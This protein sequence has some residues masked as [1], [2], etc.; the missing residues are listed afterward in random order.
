MSRSRLLLLVVALACVG[1]LLWLLLPPQPEANRQASRVPPPTAQSPVLIAPPAPPPEPAPHP[2]AILPPPEVLALPMADGNPLRARWY[3]AT[4]PDAPIVVL[5]A[6]AGSDLRPWLLSIQALLAQR[7]AH[8]LWLDD[9]QPRHADASARRLRAVARWSVALAWLDVRAPTARLAL[10]GAHEA[11]DAIWRVASRPRPMSLA[12][13]APDQQPDEP[14]SADIVDRFTLLGLPLAGEPTPT[15]VG[16][17]HNARVW[18]I[19]AEHALE[20][21]KAQADLAG[22][23]FVALGPR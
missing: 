9:V 5:D 22:W 8:V 14:L 17:L 12:V 4:K 2:P 16:Q 3:A 19:A 23:L 11:A 21:A 7:P 18:P 10:V 15:W 20:D 1:L 13:I 6:G